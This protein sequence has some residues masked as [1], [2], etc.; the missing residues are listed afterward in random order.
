MRLRAAIL[1]L[2]L[3]IPG[4]FGQPRPSAEVWGRTWAE[5][6]A[7]V[8]G[9]DAFREASDVRELCGRILGDLH[10]G[11]KKLL[12]AP[13]EDVEHAVEAWLAF[14]EQI[15]FECPASVEGQSRFD[16]D[17]ERLDWLAAEVDA[18]LA[19]VRSPS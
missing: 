8:P 19:A 15:V 5:V 3:A 1:A 6:R 16:A 4:C 12:P 14:A 7:A 13:D 18:R 17:L 11:R 10:A 2:A 9:P